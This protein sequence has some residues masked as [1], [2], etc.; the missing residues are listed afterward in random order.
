MSIVMRC[1]WCGSDPLYVTYHD[2]EWGRYMPDE[3]RLFEFLL[4][5]SA[6]AGL[7]WI[8]ILRKRE[9]YRQAFCGFN[10]AAVAAMNETD[11]VRLMHDTGI[12]R[13]S[14]KIMTAINNAQQFIAVSKEFGSF[15]AYI[16][17]F[18]PNGCLIDHC[19]ESISD[20]PTH[21]PESDA[22]SKDMHR[23]G[24][25][26]F[27]SIICYSFLQATGYINDHIASCFCRR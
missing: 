6:Q 14:R 20:V 10:A 25:Q 18:L 17:Q 15:D 9:A 8:T 26:F 22:M 24:F 2:R 16:R 19:P 27:G 21:S 11:V 5:E 1:P 12:V 3:Q 7:S 13:N 4:L 23:R